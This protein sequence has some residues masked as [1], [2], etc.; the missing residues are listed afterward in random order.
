MSDNI[1]IFDVELALKRSASKKDIAKEM[2]EGLV[3]S[4]PETSDKIQVAINQNKLTE[5][6]QLIHK[7]NGICCYTGTPNLAKATNQLE[8]QLKNGYTLE[9]LEPEF[10]EFFDHIEQVIFI[11]PEAIKQLDDSNISYY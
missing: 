8:T 4:L 1:K 3:N 9:S 5:I 7:L 10:F 11:A 2:L 6:K